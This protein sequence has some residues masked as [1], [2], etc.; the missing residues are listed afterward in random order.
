MLRNFIRHLDP[1]LCLALIVLATLDF[2]YQRGKYTD[3]PRPDLILLDL[4]LPKKDGRE[5]LAEIK[6]Q[7]VFFVHVR[8]EEIGTETCSSPDHLP[9]L[10]L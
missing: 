10:C 9:E 8:S 5:V 7:E 2:L 1:P 6:N 3:A 4:N